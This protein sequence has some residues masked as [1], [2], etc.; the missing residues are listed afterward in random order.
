MLNRYVI[1]AIPMI[2]MLDRFLN[3]YIDALCDNV[4]AVEHTFTPIVF[5]WFSG[6]L[7]FIKRMI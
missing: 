1:N 2:L 3:G 5:R 6:T 4:M 7:S